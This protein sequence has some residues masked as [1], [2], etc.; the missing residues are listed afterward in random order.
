[1]RCKKKKNLLDQLAEDRR[2]MG[3]LARNGSMTSCS[4]TVRES[5]TS[6]LGR[7]DVSRIPVTGL[8]KGDMA[9]WRLQVQV[10][11]ALRCDAG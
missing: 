5:S 10:L 1:M 7:K 3:T 6:V 4:S 9:Q 2:K 11:L 8:E